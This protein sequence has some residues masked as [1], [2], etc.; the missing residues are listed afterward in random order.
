MIDEDY[1]HTELCQWA[2]H[3]AGG[4]T[5][6]H[7][8]LPTRCVYLDKSIKSTNRT[9]GREIPE[10]AWKMD[11]AVR[12][13]GDIDERLRLAIEIGYLGTGSNVD[14]ARSLNISAA[15][16]D[17]RIGRAIQYLI[18]LLVEAGE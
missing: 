4:A 11:K 6:G 10:R 8:G 2:R 17:R 15:T 9:G 14:R 3:V 18:T 5:G 1:V 12:A 7:L 16:L 13:L